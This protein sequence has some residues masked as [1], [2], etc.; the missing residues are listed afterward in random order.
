MRKLKKWETETLV[1]EISKQL[2]REM[3]CTE[4]TVPNTDKFMKE[5]SKRF[6]VNRIRAEENGGISSSHLLELMGCKKVQGR[7]GV[8]DLF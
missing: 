2:L 1:E 6:E 4:D 7:N 8:Y 5:V 3:K